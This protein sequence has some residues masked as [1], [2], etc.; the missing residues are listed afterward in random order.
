[1]GINVPGPRSSIKS[2]RETRSASTL[3]CIYSSGMRRRGNQLVIYD[4]LTPRLGARWRCCRCIKD[5]DG[6][7]NVALHAFCKEKKKKKR[8][9]ETWGGLSWQAREKYY[10]KV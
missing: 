2:S 4:P 10:R 3:L 7:R 6:E 9:R 5:R 1:M 8:E